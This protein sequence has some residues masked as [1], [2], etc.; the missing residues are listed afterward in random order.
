MFVT[1]LVQPYWRSVGANPFDQ[2]AL[3]ETKPVPS[4]TG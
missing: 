3:R 2:R 1:F 4:N